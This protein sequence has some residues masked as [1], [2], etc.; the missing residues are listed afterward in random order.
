MQL[1]YLLGRTNSA[2]AHDQPLLCLQCHSSGQR[3]FV[4]VCVASGWWSWVGL[5]ITSIIRVATFPTMNTVCVI[6]L[7]QVRGSR[8]LANTGEGFASVKVKRAL[9]DVI[10]SPCKCPCESAS[11]LQELNLEAWWEWQSVKSEI[12]ASEAG[13]GVQIFRDTHTC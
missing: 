8:L 1:H 9:A 13:S 6:R 2:P 12:I 3:F 11:H 10:H 7:H 4:I 5:G